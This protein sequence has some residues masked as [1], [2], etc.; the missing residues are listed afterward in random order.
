L[1]ARVQ[2]IVKFEQPPE[3]IS[4]KAMTPTH[5]VIS[6]NFGVGT[7]PRRHFIVIRTG[8][9]E[10]SKRFRFQPG[11]GEKLAIQRAVEMIRTALLNQLGSAFIHHSSRD[12]REIFV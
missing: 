4:P 11:C 5:D 1:P 9:D 7:H 3:R 10:L 12:S 8:G 2:P 6:R